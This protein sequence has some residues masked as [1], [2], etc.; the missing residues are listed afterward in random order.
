MYLLNFTELVLK[1][2]NPWPD[3]QKLERIRLEKGTVGENISKLQKIPKL[4][5]LELID[6]QVKLIVQAQ[7]CCV[8]EPGPGRI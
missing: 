3:L 2:C 7:Q 5:Q 1:H 6:F 8:V 4:H